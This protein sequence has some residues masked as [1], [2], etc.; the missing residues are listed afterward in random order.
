MEVPAGFREST[1][2]QHQVRDHHLLHSTSSIIPEAILSDSVDVIQDSTDNSLSHSSPTP[3]P[4]L[5]S[6]IPAP[7]LRC[8]DKPSSSLPA[9]LTVTEDFIRASVGFR[10]IDTLKAHLGSLYADTVKLDH[11]PQDA[12]LD[13]GDFANLKKSP[14][15]TTPVPRPSRFA[16]VIHMD[17]VFGPDIAI[18]NVHYDLLFTDRYSRMTYLYPLQNLTSDIRRQLDA[19]FAHLGLTPRRLITD[20][21]TKLIG[22]K[23]REYLN[24]LAIH[25]N[26]APSNRQ[27]HNGLAE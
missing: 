19:F 18:G 16:E 6:T 7:I 26:A 21:D 8:I 17:I 23:A 20:F 25:V 9:R 4:N 11:L 5:S 10:R 2:Y 15:Y 13:S 1:S 12:I 24:S 22:G 14:R 27:D 3:L